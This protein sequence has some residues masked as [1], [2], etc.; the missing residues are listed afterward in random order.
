[1][2][3]GLGTVQFGLD[4]GISNREG[5]TTPEEVARILATAAGNGIRIIDTAVLYGASEEVLGRCLPRGHRFSIVTKTPGFE[6]GR[7]SSRDLEFLEE[8]FY[9]SLARLGQPSVYGLL[10]HHA[11]DLLAGGGSLLFQRMAELKKRGLVKKIGTSV[12]NGDEIDRIV[13]KYP[14]DLVQLPVN[15]L[16]Q[17]LLISGHL[18]KL[19]GAGIEIHARSVFLQGLL[20]MDPGSLPS[21]FDSVKDHLRSYH[22][23]IGRMGMTPVQAALGFAAGL[24]E[25]D[26]LICG[27]N[28]HR[29]LE[30]I[31]RLYGPLKREMFAEFAIDD[32][33]ILNPSL[34]K[35]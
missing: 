27:V 11:G 3:I 23:K 6:G 35:T 22:D 28:N 9:R 4:Y 33:S 29:Q 16:D 20:I 13:E 15:V 31:C 30:D 17:R 26:V 24:D 14:V 32:A 1:M 5:K 18:S 34:W 25:V 8:T 12:Y 21:H 10:V 7:I 2:K 19:K